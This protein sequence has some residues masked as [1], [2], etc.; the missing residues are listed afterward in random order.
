[1]SAKIARRLRAAS[2]LSVIVGWMLAAP[3]WACDGQPGHGCG[4]GG[5]GESP[6]EISLPANVANLETRAVMANTPLPMLFL[7]KGDR[8]FT[9]QPT[10]FKSTT[11]GQLGDQ[12]KSTSGDSEFKGGGGAVGAAW[13][14]ADRWGLHFSLTGARS[15]G[16]SDITDAQSAVLRARITDADATFMFAH[17]ALAR[18]FFGKK[19]GGFS[20]V[21]FAGPTFIRARVVQSVQRFRNGVL[22]EDYDMDAVANAPGVMGGLELSIPLGR[23]FR[24]NPFIV[25]G[26]SYKEMDLTKTK[27]RLDTG[28]F[29][30]CDFNISGDC[31][32]P[33]SGTFKP[34]TTSDNL[35][36]PGLNLFFKPL[37]LAV[38]LTA[39]LWTK[40]EGSI[41]GVDI[42]TVSVSYSF[43]NF[44]R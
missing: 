1:M 29:P 43:G 19:E 42:F 31:R 40:N 25:Y 36:A 4:G 39:P 28:A 5:S 12:N 14:F 35:G 16:E 22:A 26:T 34:A 18:Q 3:S 13:S 23:Y 7:R 41:H 20:A 32:T 38:N 2:A 15:T 33:T 21:L 27:T 44:V 10:Y 6:R 30:N 11:S 9:L 17:L 24:L 37:G 8:R